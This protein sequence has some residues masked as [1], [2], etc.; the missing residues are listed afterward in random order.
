[1]KLPINGSTRIVL[2]I[3]ASLIFLSCAMDLRA[4]C[5]PPASG[6]VGWWQGEGDASDL[7]GTN[8]GVFAGPLYAAGEVGQAFNF[9]GSGNNVRIHASPDTDVG[10]GSGMTIEAW[11]FTPDNSVGRPIV[12]WVPQTVGAFGTH[13]WVHEAGVG[14]LYVNLYDTANTSHIIQTAPGLIQVNSYQHIA[15]TYDKASGIARAFVNGTLA[16]E[17]NLGTFTP[18][19]SPDLVIGLRPNTVP[20]GPVPFLGKIDEVCLYSRALT[21]IEVQAIYVAGSGGKCSSN[22]PVILAQPSNETVLVGGSVTFGVTVRGSQPLYYQW[23]LE[24]TNLPGATSSSLGLTNVQLSDAGTY[25]L[26]VTNSIG[27]VVSSNAVL[28]V[29]LPPPCAVPPA[30]L[31]AWWPAEGNANDNEGANN[32]VFT[33]PLYAAGEVG[34]AFNFDGSGN[35]VRVPASPQMDIGAS[36]GMTIEAWIFT[37]DDTS[38]HPVVEWVPKTVGAFGTHVWVHEGGSGII[39]VNL[40]DTTGVSHI[41]Q[42]A[43]GALLNN[44]NQH[45]AVTYDKASGIARLFVNGIKVTESNL[46]TF[47]PQTSPDLSIGL[48]PNTV[49]F[50][51]TSFQGKIDEVSLYAR[52]LTPSE[53]QSIFNAGVSG[54]CNQPVPATIFEQPPGQIV[55]MGQTAT[56]QVHAGGTSPLSYQWNFQGTNIAGATNASLVLTNVQMSQAGDYSVLVTNTYGSMLSSNATLV[57]NFPPAKIGVINSTGSAGQVV[58]VPVVLTANGNENAMGFSLNFPPSL[59][60]NVGVSLGTGAAGASLQFNSSQPG[61]VGVAVAL[62]SGST[63]APGTQEVAEI[64]FATAISAH[65]T[66]APLSFGDQ[67]T[68]REL[69]DV[70]AHSLAANFTGG[71]I[72]LARSAFEADVAPRSDGDG[73]LTIVD[74]VQVGRYVAGLDSPTNSSEFQRADCAPRGTVGD[75]FLTVSDWVQAGRYAAGLDPLTL[76]GGPTEAPNG[77]VVR[78]HHPLGGNSVRTISVQGPLL[79]QGQTGN[80]IVELEA[81]GDENA[82]GFSLSFDPAVVSYVSATNGVDA[83]NA[84]MQINA[85]QAT[86]GRIGIIIGLPTNV[87]FSPGTRQIL[88]VNFQ[89]ITA[90]SVDSDLA[91]SDLPVRGEVSDTNANPVAAT[92]IKGTISVNPKPSL[93]IVQSAQNISLS[94]PTWATNYALQETLGEPVSAFGNWTNLQVSPVITNGNF[95][96][97]LPLNGS[98]Q[99]YRLQHQ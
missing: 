1:M 2:T 34:Q 62:P 91:F 71:Q 10:A 76:A 38:G 81:Q 47:T 19:T 6:L 49:P 92:F 41:I 84:A 46:G 17:S 35:N 95:G 77:E 97:T 93:G 50:G 8:N 96:I 99:F 59:L 75:G 54:K 3:I 27:S 52:A 86:N 30:N 80:A 43:A 18:Q 89:A 79:F 55:T 68:K 7:Q 56:L 12:E 29:N 65:P 73:L 64:S 5:S 67:P 37:T 28:T 83:V 4:S 82:V 16:L 33:G 88:K 78:A 45:L 22:A 31:V 40:Y 58:T 72:T 13:M 61:Q 51:P 69:S 24:G 23:T 98:M 25:A 74:W 20:F 32:G 94:W 66:S 57:V 21:P 26:Q 53:I 85:N 63:F 44:V 70:Q 48:R 87:G 39:Y 60:T 15:V 9:D 11:V 36:D 90:T 42:S 14:V